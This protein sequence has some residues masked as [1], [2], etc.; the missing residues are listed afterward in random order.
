MSS[1]SHPEGPEYK[2][3]SCLCHS[4]WGALLSEASQPPQTLEAM[5]MM[6]EGTGDVGDQLIPGQEPLEQGGGWERG[7]L[8]PWGFKDD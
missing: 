4:K 1:T 6:S 5:L 8:E 3:T 7:G 2:R